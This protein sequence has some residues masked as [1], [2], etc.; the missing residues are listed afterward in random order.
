[1]RRMFALLLALGMVLA[2]CACGE[3]APAQSEAAHQVEEQ[4][5]ALGEI[6]LGSKDAIEAAEAAY[7]A[8]SAAEKAEVRN[9]AILQAAR[10]V[11]DGL[12]ATQAA[13]DA[14]AA[15]L[16]AV[17]PF[18]GTW[19]LECP[20]Y[21]AEPFELRE[22]GSYRQG[23]YSA[24]WTCDPDAGKLV[25]DGVDWIAF[26]EDGFTKLRVDAED[27]SYA[28]VL[29]QDLEAARELKYVS[30]E[31]TNENLYD[32]LG[33]PIP[34]GYQVDEWG[35]RDNTLMY[36]YPWLW[37]A[38]GLVRMYGPEDDV[39]IELVGDWGGHSTWNGLWNLNLGAPWRLSGNAKGTLWLI[40][41]SYV[42]ENTVVDLYG[43]GYYCRT[44]KLSGGESYVD[45]YVL[46]WHI[47]V[48][49]DYADVVEFY[50]DH[51]F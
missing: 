31:L 3:S 2:L 45:P 27:Y 26:Q 21:S 48:E 19:V 11:Y 23:N 42:T 29:Q 16:A 25:I 44:L 1:M 41:E 22:D 50:N 32:W 14:E 38:Q 34:V 9:Q 49:G 18:V 39:T 33:D 36:F 5:Y 7:A 6:D 10:M 51:K 24:A 37:R 20:V 28:Y 40:R 30:V 35:N 4:I 12:A 17:Q 47:S 15:R 43:N 8:L 13:A 46:F